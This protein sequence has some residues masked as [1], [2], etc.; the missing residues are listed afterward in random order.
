MRVLVVSS[1]VAFAAPLAAAQAS[2]SGAV[3]TQDGLPVP[4]LVV[5]VEAAGQVR[6]ATTGPEGRYRVSGLAPGQY[7]VTVEAPGFLQATDARVTV[8]G[9]ARHDLVLKPAPVSEQV[10]V[11]AT[12]GD[13]PSS[14]LGTSLTAFDG[15]R[16]AEREPSSFLDVMRDAPGVAL[17]RN[18]AIGHVASAFVRGGESNAALVLI[19]G[20]PANEPGGAYNYAAQFPLELG[21]V[22]VLRGA[23][24]SLYGTDALAGVVH[25][26]TRRALPG[27]R[28]GASAELQGGD[29]SWR[30]ARGT[31]SGRSG[32][33]DWNAGLLYL[34]TDNEQPNSVFEQTGGA[35]SLGAELSRN[36]SLRLVLRGETSRAGT[37]GA[38]A[39]GRPDLDSGSE[40]DERVASFSLLHAGEFLRHEL[41]AGYA[42]TGQLSLNPIDSGS[43][44][45][46][47]G[48]RRAPFPSSDFTNPLGYQNDT[49]RSFA[50][51]Q[52][53]AGLGG[54]NL[55]TA[56]AD[57]ER[58]TGDIGDRRA[59]A[60]LSPERTNFG[61]YLQ[62]RATLFGRLFLTAGLRVESNDSY[63]TRA[64]PRGALALR[65]GPAART[66]TL[67][68]SAGAGIKEPSFL[69][70]FGV[71]SFARGNPE[72]VAEK[73]RTFDAG[74]EQRLARDRVRVEATFFHHEYRDQIA[75]TVLSLSPFVGSYINLGRTRGRGLELELDTA[76]TASLRLGGQFT[77]L[78]GEI[79]V[80]TSTNPLYAV[81]EPLLRRPKH[82][83]SLWGSFTKSR[84][85]GGLS[86]LLVGRRADSDF[87]GIGL[88]E[89][90]AYARLDARV[91]YAVGRRLELFAV[92]ENLADRQYQEVLGYP[93]LGRALRLGV[94][95]RSGTPAP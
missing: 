39:F 36:T 62:D 1:L 17:A 51:Y 59:P 22:E 70:S 6:R 4:Q 49:R 31:T 89:N 30:R 91:R 92:A 64:V 11:T 77:L 79:R 73:S 83:G 37:P 15:E 53:Q 18:G 41:R 69:Q 42:A 93:A 72:L 86:L 55:L 66:T 68:A 48:S 20:V 82:Q 34:K 61:A 47:S 26:V 74:V 9:D 81:G 46:A 52:L 5:S 33:F 10:V 44:T 57:L 60:L 84:F 67:R 23:A 88:T 14:T 40:H 13:A 54:F 16:I 21:R 45:P 90:E 76:P 8:N 50:G 28:P 35:A 71:D 85:S 25:L 94:R 95:L 2:V 32:G 63:G 56:G 38:T 58:E 24:S 80:S 19:D 65:L 87:Y 75:Y 78:D 27:E 12:R 7:R 29:F 43:Y 3:R